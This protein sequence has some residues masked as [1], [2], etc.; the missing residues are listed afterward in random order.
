MVLV[1]VNPFKGHH[2]MQ[3]QW[4][5]REYVVEKQPYPNVPVYV[6]FPRDGEG[7]SQ[8]LHRNYLLPISPNLEQGKM[9]K[10][11]AGVGNN[12]SP[13]PVPSVSDAPVEAELSGTVTPSSTGSTPENSPGDLLPFDAALKPLR[14]NFL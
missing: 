7:H 5:N 3:D 14:T 4:K 11:V 1:H 6:V 13:N 12:T 8:N 9:D 10:P 2:K